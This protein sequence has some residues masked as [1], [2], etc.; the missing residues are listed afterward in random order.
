[1]VGDR[2]GRHARTWTSASGERLR[3]A[4]AHSNGD[5]SEETADVSA[6]KD[7][8]EKV[9]QS[10][11]A[12]EATRWLHARYRLTDFEAAQVIEEARRRA[13]TP[14]RSLVRYLNGMA[15]DADGTDKGDLA[16]IVAAVMGPPAADAP[17]DKPHIRAVPA[18]CREC[19]HPDTRYVDLP[20]GRVAKCPTCHPHNMREAS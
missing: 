7:Q 16:D 6:R 4:R 5:R 19:D 15:E 10:A 12:R 13:P 20:D 2:Y 9:S 18:W 17:A 1:V 3:L 8:Q 11:Q 14:I